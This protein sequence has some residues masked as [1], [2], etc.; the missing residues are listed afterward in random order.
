MRLPQGHRP[1]ANKKKKV[2]VPAKKKKTTRSE[3][4]GYRG[5]TAKRSK[6]KRSIPELAVRGGVDSDC[7]TFATESCTESEV[8]EVTV[9]RTN[10]KDWKKIKEGQTGRTIQPIPYVPR[11]EDAKFLQDDNHNGNDFDVKITEEEV[12]AMKDPNGDIM[13]EKV[14]EHLL[15]KFDKGDYFEYLAARMRNYMLHLIRTTDYNPGTTSQ[16]RMR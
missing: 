15:P 14:A 7:N 16:T 9:H 13:F 8:E 6:V 1:A 2:P 3:R 11:P 10:P 12:E 4:R 5:K